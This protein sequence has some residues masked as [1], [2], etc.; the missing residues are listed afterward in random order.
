MSDTV[1]KDCA[2]DIPY[3]EVN[4]FPR[5]SNHVESDWTVRHC[6]KRISVWKTT[7]RRRIAFQHHPWPNTLHCSSPM[8]KKIRSLMMPFLCTQIPWR[9]SSSLPCRKRCQG[10]IEIHQQPRRKWTD[11]ISHLVWSRRSQRQTRAETRR[12]TLRPS[13]HWNLVQYVLLRR[14]IVS[15]KQLFHRS[16][17]PQNPLT[18]TRNGDYSSATLSRLSSLLF[19]STPY[20]QQCIDVGCLREARR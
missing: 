16:K 10:S 14:S 3:L 7:W 11:S 1:L 6:R 5:F 15:E 19:Q 17:L 2:E 18:P 4:R 12:T 13:R 20:A 9:R 8:S